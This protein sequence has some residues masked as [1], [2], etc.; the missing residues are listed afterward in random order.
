MTIVKINTRLLLIITIFILI[1][2]GKRKDKKDT[3][4]ISLH[5]I[6][7]SVSTMGAE[8]DVYAN[9]FD[10]NSNSYYDLYLTGVTNKM[11][12]SPGY[13]EIQFTP[14]ERLFSRDYEKGIV[15]P[16]YCEVYIGDSLSNVNGDF[17]YQDLSRADFNDKS[18]DEKFQNITLTRSYARL[19][20]GTTWNL[21]KGTINGAGGTL[22]ECG[23]D[24]TLT[25]SNDNLELVNYSEGNNIC[26]ESYDALIALD[27]P[28]DFSNLYPETYIFSEV[29]EERAS[30]SF[31]SFSTV[32]NL[33]MIYPDT[34]VL[35]SSATIDG[36]EAVLD[37]YF[38]K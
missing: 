16:I 24:N 6:S 28:I 12:G 5:H 36:A 33:F 15:A 35:R 37:Y 34:L 3:L 8:V 7:S 4:T 2:C 20:R 11:G 27:N 31:N 23:L 14:E 32:Q 22:A 18:T 21:V 26:V 30:G 29:R 17:S 9:N 25:F 19:L 10:E 13:S 38:T 1:S